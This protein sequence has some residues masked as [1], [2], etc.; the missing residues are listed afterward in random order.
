MPHLQ[1]STVRLPIHFPDCHSIHHPTARNTAPLSCILQLQYSF[2]THLDVWLSHQRTDSSS[3]VVSITGDLRTWIPYPVYNCQP[4]HVKLS[5]IRHLSMK[6]LLVWI[7]FTE[8]TA[9]T[10]EWT[11]LIVYYPSWQK[12]YI[13]DST[14][15]L[16]SFGPEK[17]S[18]NK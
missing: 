11:F 5:V 13:N 16:M 3:S 12:K 15:R 7:S 14:E 4:I 6:L 10:C 1:T 17:I 18:H 2:H 8:S 9:L